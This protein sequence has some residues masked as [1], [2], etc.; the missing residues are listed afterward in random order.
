MRWLQSAPALI[1]HAAIAALASATLLAAPHSAAFLPSALLAGFGLGPLYPRVLAMVVGTYKPRAI[2]IVAGVGSAAMPW[3]TGTLSHAAGSLG[4]GMLV[5]CAGA[6]ALLLMML[7][8]PHTA[9]I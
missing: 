6:A 5:P 9:A 2:F 4:F 3:L 1:A 7:S 8:R